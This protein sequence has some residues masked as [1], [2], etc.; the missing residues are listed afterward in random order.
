MESFQK[1]LADSFFVQYEKTAKIPLLS[2]F[3]RVG[4]S[5]QDRND[6]EREKKLWVI[7]WGHGH[8]I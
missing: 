8:V 5:V 1:I 4:I 2:I 3:F 7:G 6:K